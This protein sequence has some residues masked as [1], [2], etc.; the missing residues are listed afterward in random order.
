M[1]DL[2]VAGNQVVT[3]TG[4]IY[5]I[6]ANIVVRD[7]AR[8]V[9]RDAT[10]VV[11]Q[12]YDRQYEIRAEG[13]GTLEWSRVVLESGNEVQLVGYDD[14][15]LNLNGVTGSDPWRVGLHDHSAATVD[16]SDISRV[17]LCD[18]SQ[19]AASHSS[20]RTVDLFPG[21][22]ASIEL[23]GIRSGHFE[24]W[25]TQNPVAS[26]HLSTALALHDTDVAG[27]SV[28]VGTG[29]RV[30][31]VDSELAGIGIE[32]RNVSGRISG[33]RP[34]FYR[35]WSLSSFP[36][37]NAS[38]ELTLRD[39]YVADWVIRDGAQCDL[40]LE[41][42][43]VVLLL[44]GKDL[45]LAASRTTFVWVGL[46][47]MPWAEFD[48]QDCRV[49][50][51]FRL[52][53][54]HLGLA[55]SLHFAQP[56]EIGAWHSSSVVRSFEV[57]SRDGRGKPLAHAAVRVTD[58]YGDTVAEGSTNTNGAFKFTITFDDGSYAGIWH[59]NLTAY[60]VAKTLGFQSDTTIVL[61]AP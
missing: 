33:L 48:V 52:V 36:L 1:V 57:V 40:T 7:S 12:T 23:R 29:A 56:L 54:S 53:N 31:V 43:Q 11:D 51:Y 34:G 8:L 18:Y 61:A 21:A 19:M 45:S 5:C 26:G 32:L 16:A 17:W 35:E 58:P 47:N 14:A 49:Q 37:Q 60:G 50:G 20:I 24:E 6:S 55:G 39:T 46:S 4:Q 59:V 10:I 30:T 38:S 9:V 27:W 2:V 15:H 42:S 3:I 13:N 25:T 22:N 28:T 44:W 41:D